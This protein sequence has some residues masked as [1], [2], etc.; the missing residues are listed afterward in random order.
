MGF[1][2]IEGIIQKREAQARG[3]MD[4]WARLPVAICLGAPYRGE[5]FGET[6]DLHSQHMYYKKK[7]R[8]SSSE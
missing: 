5:R 1:A 4:F 7:A 6:A 3:K 2:G 8:G